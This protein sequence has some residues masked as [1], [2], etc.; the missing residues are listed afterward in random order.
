MRVGNGIRAVTIHNRDGNGKY[1]LPRRSRMG[2]C[3]VACSGLLSHRL[4]RM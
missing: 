2:L 3:C 1:Y 4:G